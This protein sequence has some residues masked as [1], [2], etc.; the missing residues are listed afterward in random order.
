MPD[1]IVRVGALAALFPGA[2]FIQMR[3]DA[4]DICLS[5]LMQGFAGAQGE[6]TSMADCRARAAGLERLGAHWR[7]IL[8]DRVLELDY[9]SL[10]GDFEAQARRLV[11][12][13]GCE[14][15]PR[16]LEFYATERAIA[17]ASSWQARQP[18]YAS[19]LER[20]RPYARHL[21]ELA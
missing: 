13:V 15:S 5:C 9:A 14:W 10:V 3:R 12:H 21:G 4:R 17:T 11:A 2:R 16:C 7:A 19:S 1:N 8:G 6:Y 18:L 20:W